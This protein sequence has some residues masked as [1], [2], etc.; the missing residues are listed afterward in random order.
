MTAITGDDA[1]RRTREVLAQHGGADDV[2]LFGALYD[3]GLAWVHWP[4]G[5]GGLGAAP[6]LQDRIDSTLE[7]AGRRPNWMRNPMGVGMCG[8]AVMVHGT[9]EQRHRYLRPIFTAEDIWC[10]LF[11]EPG[12]GS[13]VATLATRAVRQ[14]DRW[15]VNGQKVWTSAA[16]LARYGLLLARADPDLPKHDGLTAFILDMAAPGVDVRPLR[17]MNG[18]AHFNEVYLTDVEIPDSDRLGPE[19][20]GWSVAV[21]TLMNERATMG[22]IVEARESGEIALAL[23]SW[24]RPATARTAPRRD[25]LARLWIDAEVLRLGKLRAQQ[26][27]EQG[28]PGPEASVL[29]L[30]GAL[31]TRRTLAFAVDLLGADG[32][33]ISSY[34]GEAGPDD[35]GRAFLMAQ[36]LTIAGGTS[37]IMR[38]ILGERVLGLPPEPR[39]DKGVPWKDIPRSG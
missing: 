24:R 20:G 13:D 23:A 8:P 17:Q 32:T 4:P 5:F 16:H 9:D 29:K 19:G 30:Q 25:A 39:L 31:L 33:L 12:A 7:A 36:G 2:T 1:V 18:A 11:S 21:T 28:G 34:E 26:Q 14:P 22:G 3:A 6:G 10:Q 15:L 35:I 37:E 27:R 38:N